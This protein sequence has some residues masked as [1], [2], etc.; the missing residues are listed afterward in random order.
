[1]IQDNVSSPLIG[2]MRMQ[3]WRDAVRELAHVGPP[4]PILFETAFMPKRRR[5]I[6]Q[7]TPSR[8][9]SPSSSS[10]ADCRRTTSSG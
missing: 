9:L 7:N 1:M 5:I 4:L 2:K 8:S 10:E 6:H 3:F